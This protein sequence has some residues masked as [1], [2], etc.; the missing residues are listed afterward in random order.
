MSVIDGGSNPAC[1]SNTAHSSALNWRSGGM[2]VNASEP[3]LIHVPFFFRS[4]L[5]RRASVPRSSGTI[6]I[7][8]GVMTTSK[9]PR[10]NGGRNASP[11]TSSKPARAGVGAA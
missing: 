10:L 8:H 3:I 9:A 1:G 6:S 4:E 7:N 2:S 5:T 11:S